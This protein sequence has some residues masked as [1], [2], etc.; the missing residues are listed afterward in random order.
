MRK[1]YFTLIQQWSV[2]CHYLSLN[3]IF[4]S[5][6]TLGV[7]HKRRLQDWEE[8]F[9]KKRTHADMRGEDGGQARVDVHICLNFKYII[10]RSR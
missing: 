8:G 5:L 6:F 3:N 9:K 1:Q 2:F 7:I 10:A 4:Y